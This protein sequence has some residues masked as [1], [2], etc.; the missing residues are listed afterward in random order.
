MTRVVRI[1][2]H[3]SIIGLQSGGEPKEAR[4][5]DTYNCFH[6]ETKDE[7]A[8]ETQDKKAEKHS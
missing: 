1:V 4:A 6:T 2:A 5:K 7:T 8:K 3:P